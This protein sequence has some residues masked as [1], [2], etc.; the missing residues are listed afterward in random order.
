M[1]WSVSDAIRNWREFM[2]E[3]PDFWEMEKV[4]GLFNPNGNDGAHWLQTHK[5]DPYWMAH[6]LAEAVWVSDPEDPHH[7]DPWPHFREFWKMAREIKGYE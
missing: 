5:E 6:Q 1:L 7:F 4:P 3:G 2:P